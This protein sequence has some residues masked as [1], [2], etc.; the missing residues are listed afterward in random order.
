MPP[1]PT[2]KSPASPRPQNPAFPFCS[3]R[4]RAI[5]LGKWFT[6]SYAVPGQPSAP[7]EGAPDA[8]RPGPGRE[9]DPN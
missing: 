6:G 8:E 2:C 3:R 4:C 9:G 7:G 5:D 1:C